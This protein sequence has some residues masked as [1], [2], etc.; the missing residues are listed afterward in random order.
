MQLTRFDHWLREKFVYE[1]HI[2]TLRMPGSLP[3]GI[4]S[5]NLPDVSGKRYKCLLIAKKSK[6][7]DS[8]IFELKQNSQ[9]Y[10]TQVVEKNKWYVPWLAPKNKSVT[11]WLFSTLLI[12][13]SVIICL[14]KIKTFTDNAGFRKTFFEAI[15][16]LKK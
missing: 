6:D 14:I 1:T 5:V 10:A 15:D 12:C 11:W 8:M 16:V 9:M 13:I 3:K 4:R 7:A 2:H